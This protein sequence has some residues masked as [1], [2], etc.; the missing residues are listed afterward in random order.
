MNKRIRVWGKKK[1]NGRWEVKTK[2]MRMGNREKGRIKGKCL[3]VMGVEEEEEE[4]G[5]GIK[6]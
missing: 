6:E 1:R 2:E 5:K 4:G 3:E